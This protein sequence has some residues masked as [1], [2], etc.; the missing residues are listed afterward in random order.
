MRQ[1]DPLGAIID[2]WRPSP[3]F[4]AEGGAGQPPPGYAIADGR[5]IPA[6]QHDF[7]TGAP[8][9]LPD[10]RN[11]FVL[12]AVLDRAGSPAD[13]LAAVANTNN[14][15]D[16]PGIGGI[17]GAHSKT[18]TLPGHAHSFSLAASS[19]PGDHAHGINPS[20][21]HSHGGSGGNI[22]TAGGF[23]ESARIRRESPG[24][25]IKNIVGTGEAGDH[26]HGGAT[27]PAGGHTHSVSGS[28]GSGSSGDAAYNTTAQDF[29]PR[30][31]GLLKIMKVRRN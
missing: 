7:G 1:F 16:A 2:W 8:V 29:R 23:G 4:D 25:F 17:G 11:A 15:A 28:V 20:G 19:N 24:D 6:D 26:T 13:G 27:G 3:T 12:S 10:L 14:A 21:H 5:A 30:Y 31:V 9:T 18:V 22:I